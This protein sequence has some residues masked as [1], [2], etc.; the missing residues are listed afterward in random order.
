MQ[1]QTEGGLLFRDP[2]CTNSFFREKSANAS[3]NN[4]KK[5]G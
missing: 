4:T 5:L 2:R 1:M 3:Q